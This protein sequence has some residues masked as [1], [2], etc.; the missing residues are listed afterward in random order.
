MHEKHAEML[1]Y[2][3]QSPAPSSLKLH[4][5]HLLVSNDLVPEQHTIRLDH[6]LKLTGIA[7]TGGHAKL[8]IQNGEVL[9][10]GQVETR[11]RRKL[12]EGDIVHFAGNDYPLEKIE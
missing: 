3:N 11:R 8:L 10:N 9:V 7:D 1:C 6:F 2:K 4:G 5:S 12:V